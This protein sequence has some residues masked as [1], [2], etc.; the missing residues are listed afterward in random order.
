MLWPLFYILVV[1]Y[2]RSAPTLPKLHYPSLRTATLASLVKGRWINGKPQA[3]T[4]LRLLA[5]YLPFLY[6]KLFCRQDGGIATPLAPSMRFSTPS[7]E[8][9]YVLASPRKRGGGLTALQNRY[10]ISS[11]FCN[12]PDCFQNCY[13]FAVKTVGI[14]PHPHHQWDFPHHPSLCT[15]TLDIWTLC[16][17]RI[18]T[19]TIAFRNAIISV[20]VW[21]CIWNITS[22]TS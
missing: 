19:I 1:S 4:L 8:K 3:V 15:T 11:S 16:L 6:C 2:P 12:L 14:A 7:L 21:F 20:L 5:I 18:R 10:S 22:D 17:F 9:H 13:T